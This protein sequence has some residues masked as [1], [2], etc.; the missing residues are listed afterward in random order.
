MPGDW[1]TDD[2]E[3]QQQVD[4]ER[5][6][7]RAAR[8]L[9]SQ[10]RRLEIIRQEYPWLTTPAAMSLAKSNM[11][12]RSG[13]ARELARRAK[14]RKVKKSGGW[15]KSVGDT[16]GNIGD[17]VAPEAV[18]DAIGKALGM[19]AKP[20]KAAVRGATAA[21]L[22]GQ[23]ATAATARQ[24]V[25]YNAQLTRDTQG[26]IPSA[27][28]TIDF[29]VESVSQRRESATAL[30]DEYGEAD[31]SK[32]LSTTTLG[33]IADKF[34]QG[35][36]IDLGTGWLPGGEV[37]E[38]QRR[39]ARADLSI[40]DTGSAATIGR[41]IAYEYTEPGTTA[42]NLMSG[43]ID[44]VAAIKLDPVA[45]GLGELGALRQARRLIDP[46][47]AGM[48]Q[49]L[50]RG[51]VSEFAEK[52]IASPDGR[53]LLAK[54][55]DEPSAAKV[56][57]LF[58]GKISAEEAADIARLNTPAHIADYL[59]PKLGTSIRE[60]PFFAANPV[61]RVVKPVDGFSAYVP[62]AIK[63]R[64]DG[65]RL[66]HTMPG[67][68][69][70]PNDPTDVA[71]NLQRFAHNAKLGPEFADELFNR[72][73]TA[74]GPIAQF[75]VVAGAMS[76]AAKTMGVDN[77]AA[78]K[79]TRMWQNASADITKYFTN[80]VGEN[81]PV[82]GAV[83]NG[84]DSAL[85]T[86]HLFL[87]YINRAIP[88]PDARA[89][90]RATSRYGR[91]LNHMGGANGRTP[92]PV[93]MLDFVF[94]DV[95]KPMQLLRGAWT[96][97]VVG[98]EQIR[99]GAHGKTSLFNHPIQHIAWAVGRKGGNDA[100]GNEWDALDDLSEFARAQSFRGGEWR[101]RV[102]RVGRT[103][104]YRGMPTYVPS[105]ADEL[106]LLH[107]DPIAA[108]VAGGLRDGDSMTAA[109]TGD[110][111]EDVKN[112][113][114]GGAG[115]KFRK[116]IAEAN[117]RQDLLT[118][119][120]V[121]DDL[122]DS[123][124]RRIQIKTAGN[125][126]LVE[127]IGAGA[128]SSVPMFT[129]TARGYTATEALSERLAGLAAE[130]RSPTT[131]VSEI[132]RRIREG[133]TADMRIE[134][135]VDAMF[136][137]LMSRPTNFLSRSPA[138]R[139]Y[140]WQRLEELMPSLDPAAQAN[141]L[142]TAR[143][144]NLGK[145]ALKRM[146]KRAGGAGGDLTLEDADVIAK[147]YGLDSTKKLLYDMSEKS[148]FFDI[149]RHIFPFGE[150]WKEVL[151]VWAK[152]VATR[153]Q[154]ARRAQVGIQGALGAGFFHPNE[155][156]EL[157]FSYPGTGWIQRQAT[158]LPMGDFEGRVASLN[159][160]GDNPL[161]PGFGPA[162]QILAGPLL[163]NKPGVEWLRKMVLPYGDAELDNG[164]IES[165]FPPWVQK[166]RQTGWFPGGRD[167]DRLWANTV[168]EVA[169]VL[170]NERGGF[171][172]WQDAESAAQPVAARLYFLRGIAQFAAPSAPSPQFQTHDAD[173]RLLLTDLLAK[174]WRK[175][176]DEDRKNNTDTAVSTFL[177]IYGKDALLFMQ[178]KS[179]GSSDVPLSPEG[180]EWARRNAKFARKYPDTY[181]LFAPKSEDGML[182]YEAYTKA[183]KDGTIEPL[184]FRE[185]FE[186][187]QH[188]V[189]SMIYRNYTKQIGDKPTDEQQAWLRD[190]KD[191]LVE[192]YPGYNPD[193]RAAGKTQPRIRELRSAIKDAPIK[194][195]PVAEGIRK[196]LAARD[197]A[198]AE[199]KNR[200]LAGFGGAKSA[201]DLRDW[202][203][204]GASVLSRKY[205]GFDEVYSRVF[206]REFETDD[207][208]VK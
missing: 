9:A 79:L 26:F 30:L 137:A 134:P 142:A 88:L 72:A 3:P 6:Q 121:A 59:A 33:V 25:K 86:P 63:K 141:V 83:V 195:T 74:R 194:G 208:A 117:G 186:L 4:N 183:I 82:L 192:K 66:F 20:A 48:L 170:N 200:G 135:A 198:E 41:L 118:N 45:A 176:A 138:F 173:G 114:W 21:S 177:A 153:P 67:H 38:E 50:R 42:Y 145:A 51:V 92:V 81:V 98:E 136:N 120:G 190:L 131:V 53:K 28:D 93:A 149:T 179:Q 47:A 105:W 23:E 133:S 161:V 127:A 154:V 40:G 169:M 196:Y 130:G 68:H 54:L 36:P 109:R 129:R 16:I 204:N 10:A 19:Q 193:S 155:D 102:R 167:D 147:A 99:M 78:N 166:L 34:S 205:K 151:G 182:D 69:V 60:K 90:R 148:Q 18:E 124:W 146:E 12:V 144:A 116:D 76:D 180:A 94:Q 156:G 39:R 184:T 157:M 32:L 96:V 57:K 65:V 119:R 126:E 37:A 64:I 112:W 61:S 178:P 15:F 44:G 171:D 150:A 87:E 73:A 188:R 197:Q 187:G 55:A 202:L 165:F 158:G 17:F 175:L 206:E 125:V 27:L 111:I 160:M 152:T 14:D 84:V 143:E 43:F 174:E 140:Y 89:I 13:A 110:A 24:A 101:D 95:W 201:R 185:W 22:V 203:R 71:V 181:A 159:L 29:D 7:R 106:A 56:F 199:A 85:P 139:E 62:E 46:S 163:Q 80:D 1:L 191:K 100:I 162:I 49:G 70:D 113:F 8:P 31:A 58:G 132:T 97:R 108:R 128:Y 75:N 189:A 172:T 207:E 11:G 122:I 91:V 52:Y 168:M 103:N 35:K 164:L 123:Y 5:E 115:Q 104:V 107:A 77:A 2:T